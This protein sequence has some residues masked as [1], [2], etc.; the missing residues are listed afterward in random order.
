MGK[1]T[2]TV[3][4]SHIELPLPLY[5]SHIVGL[6]NLPDGEVLSVYA[7]LS[8]EHVEKLQAHARDMEDVELQN[9]TSDYRR[10]VENSYEDWYKKERTPFA[11]IGANGQLA[12][13]I[14]FGPEKMPI[15]SDTDS[16][17]TVA[18]RSYAPYRGKGIMTPF[19]LFA[20]SKYIELRPGRSIWLETGPSNEAAVHLYKKL[21]FT[22][23]S[24]QG[25]A[26]RLL[27]TFTE[28]V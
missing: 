22:E 25:H 23:H 4:D 2:F 7:G 6:V 13:L 16:W 20:I 3:V 24:Y 15:E 21:G 26:D 5:E 11:L 1:P 12:A 17:D 18:F 9:N 8:K 27:M 28:P 10:F 19:G 14:W